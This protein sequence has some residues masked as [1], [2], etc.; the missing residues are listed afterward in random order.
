MLVDARENRLT[1]RGLAGFQRPD[2]VAMMFAR[3]LC[4]YYYIV[5]AGDD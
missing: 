4:S 3:V 5:E 1:G 2:G